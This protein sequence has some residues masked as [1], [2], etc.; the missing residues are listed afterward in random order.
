[1]SAQQHGHDGDI[2]KVV[3]LRKFDAKYKRPLLLEF[4]NAHVKNVIMGYVTNLG[5]AK[6]EFEG[7]T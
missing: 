1:L 2:V 3:R 5:S 7:V 4:S 6:K